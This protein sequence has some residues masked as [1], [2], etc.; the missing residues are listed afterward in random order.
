MSY[1]RYTYRQHP[2]IFP[3]GILSVIFGT[4]GFV[5]GAYQY[6]RMYYAMA[7][8]PEN[9]GLKI[10]RAMFFT[11]V[12]PD[13]AQAV[14]AHVQALHL[15]REENMDP[16]SNEVIGMKAEFA[17]CLEK[18]GR[19][20]EALKLMEEVKRSCMEWIAENNDDAT[21]AGRRTHILLWACRV[22]TRIADLYSSP[23]MPDEEKVEENL[24]WA[25]ET[26]IRES[27]RR[28]KEGTKAGEGD[29]LSPDEQGAEYEQLAHFY[30]GQ[31]K[32]YFAAQLFLQALMLKPEKDC[33]AVVLMNNLATAI[34]QQQPPTEPGTAPPSKE[35]LRQ[36]GR[37]WIRQA[38][39][40]AET[41]EPP[42]RNAECD[43]GCAVAIHNLGE[44]AEMDGNIKEAR[45]KYEEAGSIAHAI[46]FQEGVISAN[47]GVKRLNGE[48]QKK[49]R[50][51]GWFL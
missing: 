11:E 1:L 40:L 43:R 27:Q 25:V 28:Q 13:P 4:V 18:F 5:W 31:N 24:V 47:E 29:W 17:R 36:S 8:F 9:V 22:S 2:I 51:R 7:N 12:D 20:D 48:G 32:H 49:E 44:F 33:H 41:I 3:L 6:A 45:E 26:S 46:G 42:L 35:Q 21:Q 37:T 16:F 38:L 14:R 50:R 19:P 23:I 34:V 39:A 30:E 10:R 15:A